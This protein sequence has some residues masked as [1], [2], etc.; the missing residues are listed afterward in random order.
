MTTNRKKN[1]SKQICIN[2]TEPQIKLINDALDKVNADQIL[3][4]QRN[5][6]IRN[7]IIVNITKE[8]P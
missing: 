8:T 3:I 6:F 7:I 5:D 2:F 1:Y 4:I